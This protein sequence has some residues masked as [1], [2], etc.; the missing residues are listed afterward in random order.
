M[1]EHGTIS[2]NFSNDFNKLVDSGERDA[3]RGEERETGRDLGLRL[4][5]SRLFHSTRHLLWYL[6]W[7]WY[8]YSTVPVQYQYCTGIG[9]F[10]FRRHTVGHRDYIDRLP[11]TTVL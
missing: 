6:A 3:H 10:F 7:Y 5:V 9:L 1:L 4:L 11:G 8:M 2:L